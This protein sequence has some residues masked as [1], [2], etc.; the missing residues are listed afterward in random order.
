MK[1]DFYAL[2]SHELR[3]PLTA[4]KESTSLF[5]EGRAGQVTDKQKRLLAIMAEE[6]NRLIELVNSLLDLSRLEASMVY[7][8][9]TRQCDLNRADRRRR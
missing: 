7:Y 8:H 6:S 5:L 4:I 9:F 1:S 3:T 2:M